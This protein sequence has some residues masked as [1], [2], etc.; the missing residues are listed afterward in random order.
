[1]RAREEKK[2]RKAKRTPASETK[3]ADAKPWAS[4]PPARISQS[5]DNC[6]GYCFDA[7]L[8][9]VDEADRRFNQVVVFEKGGRPTRALVERTRMRGWG[10]EVRYTCFDRAMDGE[11]PRFADC[12]KTP[13]GDAAPTV[14]KAPADEGPDWG[15]DPLGD[16]P[17]LD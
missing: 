11:V 6:I 17:F 9:A 10:R 14:V 5:A 3:R 4:L 1:M 12:R 8:S 16:A 13:R 2:A 7:V 15:D